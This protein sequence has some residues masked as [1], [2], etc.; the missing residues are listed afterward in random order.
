MDRQSVVLVGMPG[1]GK[2]TVGILLAKELGLG[3]IDTDVAIQVA[4]G[5]TLQA[6]LDQRGY[7]ALREI[8]SQVI[9]Q[10]DC[11]ASVVATGGSAVYGDQ[12]MAYLR[13]L[14]R[15]V[16]IDVSLAVLRARI[17]NYDS[18][19]IARRPDQS[20]E[21]LYAERM[22]LYRQYADIAIPASA[23]SVPQL[24]RAIVTALAVDGNDMSR[25][26]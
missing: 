6:I 2:S 13:S 11:R 9:L 25:P 16:F 22:A 17:D 19:G 14:G 15:I 24:L 12:A 10:T 18:R 3:F 21:D 4:Q 1:A 20:F 7:L 23:M 5:E 8:E 26:R